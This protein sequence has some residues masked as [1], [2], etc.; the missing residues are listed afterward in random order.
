MAVRLSPPDSTRI[1]SSRLVARDE[2]VDRV[3]VRGDVVTDRGV[4]AAAGLHGGDPAVG[5]DGVA[6]QEVGVFGGVDVV[7]EHRQ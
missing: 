3:E 4:R 5:Q 2:V 1:R 6:A 7:G